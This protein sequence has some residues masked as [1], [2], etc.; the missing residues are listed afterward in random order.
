LREGSQGVD[1]LV[2]VADRPPPGDVGSGSCPAFRPVYR[3]PAR[4]RGSQNCRPQSPFPR[5]NRPKIAHQVSPRKL[6]VQYT[7]TGPL[8]DMD[9]TRELII[10]IS[11]NQQMGTRY[12][13]VVQ[14]GDRC[15]GRDNTHKQTNKRD[16]TPPHPEP[17]KRPHNP[18]TVF[19]TS[20]RQT[21]VAK[22]SHGVV[23]LAPRLVVGALL[24]LE[25]ALERHVLLLEQA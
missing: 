2:S 16:R 8:H 23:K 11:Q 21:E 4:P 15:R 14:L 24:V 13:I 17:M 7:G 5:S 25:L 12:G 10:R 22:D 1:A 3:P 6:V 20:L 19:H 18:T 9:E